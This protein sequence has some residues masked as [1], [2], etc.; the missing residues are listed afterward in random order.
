M[1][2]LQEAFLKFG[3]PQSLSFGSDPA[4]E[5][6]QIDEIC[7]R[8]DIE[9]IHCSRHATG[10]VGKIKRFFRTLNDRWLTGYPTPP[11][12]DALNKGLD[13]F[14]E[15]YNNLVHSGTS[16]TPKSR[17]MSSSENVKR[18]SPE[19]IKGAFADA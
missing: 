2:T 13:K 3:I 18:L 11:D 19:D 17:W 12:L 4:C 15:S 10:K 16:M 8:L 5:R 9:A 6:E 14:I 1:E 7:E